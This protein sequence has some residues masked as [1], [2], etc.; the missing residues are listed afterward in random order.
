MSDDERLL[1]CALSRAVEPGDPL[2][3]SL[4]HRV[5]ARR[6]Y[7][8]LCR[9]EGT[10]ADPGLAT[11]RA[12]VAARLTHADPVGDLERADRLGVRFVVPGDPDWPE[13]LADLDLAEP[14]QGRGGVPVGLWV[15]GPAPLTVLERAV[16]VVGSRSAT[17]Y[18]VSLA[19]D[20][21]AD[22]ARAGMVV[23]SGAAFGIDQA[24]HRGALA[25]GGTS[26][27]VL[28]GGPERPYPA[29]HRS[30]ID[31]M[32]DTG[33][34]LSETPPGSAPTRMRFLA[35]NRII[36]ALAAG[37]VVVEAAVRSGALNTSNWADR[38]S[39]VVAGVP[40]PVT[41]APSQGVHQL[42]RRGA[43]LVTCGAEVLELVGA[44]GEHLVEP[45][46]SP[47]APRDTL[48]PRQR[49]ILDAVPVNTAAETDAIARAA[50][51]GMVEVEG[52][53]RRLGARDFVLRRGDGW[54]LGPRARRA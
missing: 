16:A 21:S 32:A 19:L 45:S 15:R 39:R 44:A 11:A 26:V 13:Q 42:L 14:V 37:T 34:V 33:A 7:D 47:V 20:I 1:R 49:Q 6:T 48:S 23:L 10:R 43:S 28:A 4:V 17:T 25:A 40:G 18:G 5:G 41:S 50:G 52:S 46:R 38:L 31:H 29:A 2:V 27:A 36:A 9:R 24:A 51:I 22:L 12:D 53:L 30:L 54:V 35:R 3:L 8:A